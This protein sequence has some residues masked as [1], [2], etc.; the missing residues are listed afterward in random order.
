M[1]P[2]PECRLP[3]ASGRSPGFI[4]PIRSSDIQFGCH[5]LLVPTQLGLREQII[6]TAGHFGVLLSPDGFPQNPRHESIPGLPAHPG[7]VV[8]F[9]EQVPWYGNLDLQ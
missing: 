5:S 4:I 1:E 7:G 8:D 3:D 6:Q 2:I 9:Q